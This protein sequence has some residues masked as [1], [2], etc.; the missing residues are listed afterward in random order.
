MHY[1]Q[2]V[3]LNVHHQRTLHC[4][5]QMHSRLLMEDAP[6]AISHVVD[7]MSQTLNLRLPSLPEPFHAIHPSSH[8]GVEHRT[9]RRGQAFV[10]HHHTTQ[11]SYSSVLRH[12][13]SLCTT[14]ESLPSKESDA[15]E[16]RLV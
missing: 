13:D 3:L 15:T 6:R 14:D 5:V 7:V 10:Q 8:L 12:V 11:A 2:Q 9:F 1:S 16:P 4:K